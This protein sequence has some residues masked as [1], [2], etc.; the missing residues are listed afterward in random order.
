MRSTC[1][2]LTDFRYRNCKHNPGFDHLIRAFFIK[3]FVKIVQ[4]FC[5]FITPDEHPRVI[6]DF[7]DWPVE[8]GRLVRLVHWHWGVTGQWEDESCKNEGVS[9]SLVTPPADLNRVLVAPHE[10]RVVLEKSTVGVLSLN[11]KKRNF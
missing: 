3:F 4:A 5:T 9:L 2:G 8:N 10:S 7:G 11:F 6:Y 1:S